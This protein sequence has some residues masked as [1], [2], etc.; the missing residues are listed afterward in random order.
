MSG[1]LCLVKI[2]CTYNSDVM[3]Y[4]LELLLFISLCRTFELKHLGQMKT[5]YPEA[6]IFRQEKN[7]PGTYDLKQYQQYQLT[8][9]AS[10]HVGQAGQDVAGASS[11]SFKGLLPQVL[12]GRRRHFHKNL[13]QVVVEHHKVS[14]WLDQ[15]VPN[16]GQCC[17]PWEISCIPEVSGFP[18]PSVGGCSGPALQMGQGISSKFCPRG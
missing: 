12:V 11:A 13:L 8:V 10:S 7:I 1:G 6:F 9:E 18:D 2:S 15:E 17:V 16:A 3:L 4:A 14:Y 5:V